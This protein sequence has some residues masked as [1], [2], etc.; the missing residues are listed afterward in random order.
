MS[1]LKR[2]IA[3]EFITTSTSTASTRMLDL[4]FSEKISCLPFLH[5]F[6]LGP[7]NAPATTFTTY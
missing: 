6:D 3:A 5:G 4:V 7:S 1:N 2:S